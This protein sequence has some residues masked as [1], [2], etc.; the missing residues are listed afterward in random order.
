MGFDVS[1]AVSQARKLNHYTDSLQD[2]KKSM[3][4]YKE[5]INI[6]WQAQELKHYYPATMLA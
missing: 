3:E 4:T 5:N 6:Q 1:R 2:I